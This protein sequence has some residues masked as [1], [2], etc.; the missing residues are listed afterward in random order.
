M[1]QHATDKGRIT[2]PHCQHV[3]VEA[4]PTNACLYF[5]ECVG[6][7]T[8]LRPKAGD[9]CV[10]CSFGDALCPPRESELNACCK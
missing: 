3:S 6:C 7:G 10:F 2:C 4:M 9:C 1:Q 8:L 5:F